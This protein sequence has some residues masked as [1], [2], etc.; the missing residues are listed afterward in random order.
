[1]YNNV[2]MDQVDSFKYLRTT[3][4]LRGNLKHSHRTFYKTGIKN[5]DNPGILLEQT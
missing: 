3:F 2:S 5:Y 1:M 4:N